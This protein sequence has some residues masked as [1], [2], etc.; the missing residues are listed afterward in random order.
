MPICL[1]ERASSRRKS[2]NQ[3][4]GKAFPIEFAHFDLC[5]TGLTDFQ[6]RSGDDGTADYEMPKRSKTTRLYQSVANTL[7]KEI[8]AGKFVNGQR[9]PAERDLARRF[10]VSRPTI[11]EAMI[12]LEIVG[13]VDV[14]KGS[15]VYVENDRATTGQVAELDIGP[16]ELV[17]ARNLIECETAA[18]AAKQANEEDISILNSI[19][20]EMQQEN[21]AGIS[22]EL[23]DREFHLAIAR[24][25]Q[26]SAVVGA[27]TYLWDVRYHSP[28]CLRLMANIRQQGIKPIV[29]DHRKIVDAIAS[30]DP[31]AARDAMRQHLTGVVEGLL[32]ATEVEAM[33]QTKKEIEEQRERFA[34]ISLS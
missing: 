3:G 5:Y 11:R 31:A 27:L 7:A 15:G 32:A 2:Q 13:F 28:L 9:L 30:G 17:E 19:V 1:A 18:L 14:R 29:E 20:D 23:A 10:N 12:A 21:R 25:S 24:I 33:K 8:R 22:G 26:N 34:R 16:F 6:V 4:L